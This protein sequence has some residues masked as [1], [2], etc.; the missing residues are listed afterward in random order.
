MAEAAVD[1]KLRISMDEPG[2]KG[3]EE[4]GGNTL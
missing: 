4:W 1:T 2:Q 3:I